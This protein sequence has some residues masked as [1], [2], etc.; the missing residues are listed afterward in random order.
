MSALYPVLSVPDVERASAFY[1]EAL[2]LEPTFESEWYIS[3]ASADHAQQIAFVASNHE[4]IPQG[5]SATPQGF[6]VT[7]ELDDV[8]RLYERARAQQREIA[9]SL[10]DEEWGQRHFMLVDPNRVLVDVIKVIEPTEAYADHYAA[11]STH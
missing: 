11:D 5:F 6:L 3:L 8:D 9:L 4:S 7:V 1:R 2:E 10:R